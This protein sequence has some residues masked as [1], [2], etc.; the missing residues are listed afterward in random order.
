MINNQMNFWILQ[1]FP[2]MLHDS[3]V[4]LYFVHYFLNH[5]SHLKQ[6]YYLKI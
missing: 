5:Q 3:Y 1:L 4:L 6:K 2:V